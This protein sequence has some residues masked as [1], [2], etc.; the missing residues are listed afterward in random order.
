MLG[1]GDR[2][3]Q[4]VGNLLDNALRW[5]GEG[6]PVAVTVSTVAGFADVVVADRGPGV[7]PEQREA[8]F[9]PFVTN[10]ESGPGLGLSVAAELATAMGGRLLVDDRPGGGALFT[11]RLPLVHVRPQPPPQPAHAMPGA[12]G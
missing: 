5:T 6:T 12:P 10:H 2:V 8:I 1:D 4:I 11:L 9:R 3:L 7:P